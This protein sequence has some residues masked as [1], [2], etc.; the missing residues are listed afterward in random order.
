MLALLALACVT[1]QAKLLAFKERW[2]SRPFDDVVRSNGIPVAEYAMRDGG[3]IYRFSF[4]SGSVQL[5]SNTVVTSAVPGQAHAITSGGGTL[6]LACVLRI[7]TDSDGAI[8][9]IEI[10]RDTLGM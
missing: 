6:E 3:K 5:P 4:G 8:T 9:T 10:E 7:A 1:P 2:V